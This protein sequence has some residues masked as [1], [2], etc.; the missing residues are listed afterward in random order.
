MQY[1]TLLIDGNNLVYRIFFKL[2]S[3][4]APSK[5]ASSEI[6]GFLKSIVA[7][8]KLYRPEY[9]IVVWDSPNSLRKLKYPTYKANRNNR[10]P[11]IIKYIIEQINLIKTEIKDIGICSLHKNGYEA[12]DIIAVLCKNKSLHPVIITSA[13]SDLYQLLNNKVIINNYEGEFATINFKQKF[14]F[15]PYFYTL[16]KSLV[17]DTSDNI[18]GVLGIGDIKA[19]KLLKECKYDQNAIL[20]RLKI[21]EKEMFINA[22]KLITLPYNKE[23]LLSKPFEINKYIFNE[24]AVINLLNRYDIKSIRLLDF[25]SKNK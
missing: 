21:A 2:P 9:I 14:G 10:D 23:E 8:K 16:Y 6:Y 17:G 20:D 18:K 22:L 4:Y 12:D 11:E 13:D 1:K 3:L 5:E 19:K 15:E 25:V 7:F 24:R